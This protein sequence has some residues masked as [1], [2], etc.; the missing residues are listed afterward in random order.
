MISHPAVYVPNDVN[1]EFTNLHKWGRVVPIFKNSIYP[2]TT[3]EVKMLGLQAVKAL[4]NFDRET[5]M[6]ALIGD[7][8][9]AVLCVMALGFSLSINKITVLKYDKHLGA[10]Y[11]IQMELP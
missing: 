7:P 4:E 3:S 8:A 6:L 5:D 1:I 11:P 9:L 10:Y 2:D